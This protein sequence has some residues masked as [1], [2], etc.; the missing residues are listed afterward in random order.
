MADYQID[1]VDLQ[2]LE[3][4]SKNARTAYTEIAEKLIVS[5]GTIHVRMKKMEAAGIVRGTEIVVDPIKLGIDLTAIIGVFLDKGATYNDVIDQLDEIEEI[6][7][8][9]YTTGGY[10][11]F[12]K[13]M[14]KNTEN[15]RSVLNEKIQRV[16]GILRTETI[17][18]LE[19]SIRRKAP[20]KTIKT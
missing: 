14:C 7:E 4:L 15:L 12:L 10:S 8:A 20:L 11:I 9:Y 17:I 13:V 18:S 2:I 19:Q 5:A 6:T 1:N 16:R 3:I